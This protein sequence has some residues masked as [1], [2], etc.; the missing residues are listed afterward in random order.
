MDKYIE[1]EG[2]VTNK[3][4]HSVTVTI[5][6][7]S[8]CASCQEKGACTMADKKDKI[9][10]IKGNYNVKKGDLVTVLMQ[11]KLGLPALILGYILPLVLVITSLVLLLSL[12]INEALSGLISILILLPYY[13]I[14]RIFRRQIDKKFTFAL[15]F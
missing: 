9:V 4:D 10:D 2:I 14:L 15:K 3:T 7:V 5:T 11:Q 6:T 13:I 1:H 12:S 8:A